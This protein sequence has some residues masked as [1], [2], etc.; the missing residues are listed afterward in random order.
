MYKD[1]AKQAKETKE[2]SEF[3]RSFIGQ[4]IKSNSDLACLP[5]L[6]YIIGNI[7]FS[8]PSS[9]TPKIN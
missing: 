6:Q 5:L 7:N 4:M 2:A 8:L 9:G 3:Y 1:V